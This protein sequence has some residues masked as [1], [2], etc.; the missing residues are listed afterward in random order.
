MVLVRVFSLKFVASIGL[1][2]IWL[3]TV[4]LEPFCEILGGLDYLNCL[5][6]FGRFDSATACSTG[7]RVPLIEFLGAVIGIFPL[8]F[9]LSLFGWVF[10]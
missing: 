4:N 8:I 2:E 9:V 7:Q 3:F 1:S 5:V 6:S 10:G